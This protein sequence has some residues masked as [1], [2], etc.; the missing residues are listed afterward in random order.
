MLGKLATVTAREV[1]RRLE[2][3]EGRHT[4]A[5]DREKIQTEGS[6]GDLQDQG[7]TQDREDTSG[8]H[9]SP[10]SPY[11][12]KKKTV[13]KEKQKTKQRLAQKGDEQLVLLTVRLGGRKVKSATEAAF[14]NRSDFHWRKQG[15]N[16]S[17]GKRQAWGLRTGQ[18]QNTSEG[19][20]MDRGEVLWCF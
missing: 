9:V 14:S 20:W 11:T 8:D 12:R 16:D 5:N 4:K 17:G 1:K 3:D 6:G 7:R 2:R 15:P 10:P 18:W 19:A 13:K